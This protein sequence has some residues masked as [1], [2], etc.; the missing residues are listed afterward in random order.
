MMQRRYII[1]LV[2][3]Q[4]ADPCFQASESSSAAC[5]PA[6]MPCARCSLQGLT[7]EECKEEY[8]NSFCTKLITLKDSQTLDHYVALN[9]LCAGIISMWDIV[10]VDGGEQCKDGFFS[11]VSLLRVATSCLF[12]PTL[13]CPKV[14]TS[15]T[16]Q[17][18]HR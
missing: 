12:E 8:L 6:I 9:Q 13:R 15:C 7:D 10:D 14:S 1:L 3:F 16:S 4:L 5:H 11:T 17:C 18:L 2:C